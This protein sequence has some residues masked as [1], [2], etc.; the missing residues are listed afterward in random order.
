MTSPYQTVYYISRSGNTK[1]KK[2]MMFAD[3]PEEEDYIGI[4][5]RAG[6]R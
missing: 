6:H 1:K 5:G 3:D 4:G 2:I